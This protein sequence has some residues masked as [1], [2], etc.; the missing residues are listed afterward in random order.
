MCWRRAVEVS[1]GGAR[2]LS[3]DRLEF[4]LIAADANFISRRHQAR[5][6]DDLLV[7]ESAVGR[8]KILNRELAIV[9]KQQRVFPRTALIV[10]V[11]AARWVTP[12]LDAI[13]RR[14]FRSEELAI[15]ED[16]NLQ[17][18][19]Q[20]SLEPKF[21]IALVRSRHFGHSGTF[22]LYSF[23]EVMGERPDQNARRLKM[24]SAQS[25]VS[26]ISR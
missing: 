11:N 7:E 5:S 16:E 21:S 6:S 23:V 4:N 26:S 9:E 20:N 22:R 24:V 2:E 10:E 25:R 14:H 12:H 17:D 8:S 1:V 18:L 15:L 3:L 19:R 13:T